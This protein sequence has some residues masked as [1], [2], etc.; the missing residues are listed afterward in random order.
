MN[1][2]ISTLAGSAILFAAGLAVAA[3]EH[4][5]HHPPAAVGAAALAMTAG[6]VRKV[7]GELGKVTIRHEPIANLDMPAMTMVFSADKEL[8]KAVKSGD[9]VVFR[10]ESVNGGLVVTHIQA[11]K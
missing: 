11:R 2:V 5:Q 8:L 3:Q 10:A 4:S 9:K 7:D 1:R 6:E